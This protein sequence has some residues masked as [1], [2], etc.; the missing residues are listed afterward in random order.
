MHLGGLGHLTYC[1]N[2]H[3]GETLDEVRAGLAKHLPAIKAAVVPGRPLGV[4][5]RLGHQAAEGLRDKAALA[6]LKRFLDEGGYYVFTLNGFP[7]GAFH[8]R[9]VKEDAYRPDWSEPQRLAYTDHLA[10]L[11]AALLPAGQDGSVSTVP[12][13]FKPWAE[14]RMDAIIENLIRHVAHLVG[15]ARKAGRTIELAL[16][17]E[18][19]CHLE[20]IDE[21]VAFFEERL[22]ARAGVARLAALAGLSPGAAEAALRR[23]IGVC[24]DVCH[25]AVEFEDPKASIAQ[26]R[27]SGIRIGKLQLSSA[28]KVASMDKQGAQHLA[29]FAEPVY[30]HQV[31]QKV[32]GTLRRFVDLPQALAE[33]GGAA[34]A[35]WRVHFHVPVFLEQMAHFGTTQ[36]F[37][38]EILALHRAAPISAHLEVETYTWDVLP[39]AYRNV[40]LSSAI[41]RELNWVKAQLTQ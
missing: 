6:E 37:L 30:L 17:P 39:E 33:A 26:L 38:A 40:D 1:T 4:G 34:G 23:H 3:A 15:I 14:G 19:Y 18:P 16:E 12:C 21:T 31:V 2:I 28:L 32:N 7:Y 9:A 25:A 5:L 29:A 41:A 27:A 35:E 13:T 24:Y 20:T 22:F 11:L 8:G 36:A 10:D